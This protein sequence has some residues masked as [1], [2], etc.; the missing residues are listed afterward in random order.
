LFKPGVSRE[1]GD[2]KDDVGQ[3]ANLPKKWQVGNLPHVPTGLR[4]S[5]NWH[6]PRKA[7]IATIGPLLSAR[8]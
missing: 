4:C 8:P 7:V 5:P 6:F 1:T 3:V 2:L